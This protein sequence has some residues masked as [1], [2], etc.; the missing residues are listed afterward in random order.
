METAADKKLTNIAG[1][2]TGLTAAA[3]GTF[4]APLFV[5]LLTQGSLDSPDLTIFLMNIAASGVICLPTYLVVCVPLGVGGGRIGLQ[6]ARAR[7]STNVKP[8]VWVG[9]AVGGVVG[10]VLSSLVAFSVGHDAV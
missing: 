6:I 4:A 8:W 7:G 9:A 3:L 5:T 10:Y 1:I 2:V